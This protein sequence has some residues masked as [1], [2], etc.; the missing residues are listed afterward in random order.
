MRDLRGRVKAA[1]A[2]I[3]AAHGGEETLQRDWVKAACFFARFDISEAQFR[4]G[5]HGSSL[6]DMRV[7]R[8]LE[9]LRSGSEGEAEVAESSQ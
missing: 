8:T 6:G 5:V 1:R 9:C 3:S 2:A 4:H 7:D